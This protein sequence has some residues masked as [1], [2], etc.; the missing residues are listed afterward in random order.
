MEVGWGATVFPR[1]RVRACAAALATVLGG[2]TA[3][4]AASGPAGADAP[5]RLYLALGDSIA[6]GYVDRGTWSGP[7]AQGD[8]GDPG[9]FIGYPAYAGHAL[10]LDT[11]DAACPGETAT[12]FIVA[13]APDYG[14]ADYRAAFALHTTY[15]GSSQ[16]AFA[17]RFLDQHVN[18]RLVTVGLGLNDALLLERRCGG[19]QNVACITF[20]LPAVLYSVTSDLG[21]ILSALRATRFGGAVIVVNYYSVDYDDAAATSFTA[22]LDS[23]INAAAAANHVPVADAFTAFRSAAYAGAAGDTCRAGLLDAAAQP[24]SLCD[25]HPSAQ[26]QELLAAAVEQAYARGT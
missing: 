13:G 26:G 18:T 14:C 23:A 17:L 9:A 22:A 7:T 15:P 5:A 16:L 12:S 3:L 10:D 11:V 6:F 21:T 2:A 25:L 20:G 24:G 19:L 8:Y 4:M 1:V